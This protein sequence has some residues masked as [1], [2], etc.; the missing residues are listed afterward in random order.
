M[1]QMVKYMY[2]KL[3]VWLKLSSLKLKELT[4][5]TFLKPIIGNWKSKRKIMA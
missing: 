4:I 2:R 1:F 5:E 3:H